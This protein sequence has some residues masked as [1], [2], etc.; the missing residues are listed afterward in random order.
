MGS[1][2]EAPSCAPQLVFTRRQRTT[3][4]LSVSLVLDL[5]RRCYKGNVWEYLGGKDP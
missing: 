5:S 2:T 1:S 3:S 4:I